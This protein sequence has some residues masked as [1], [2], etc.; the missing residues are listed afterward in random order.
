MQWTDDAFVLSARRHGEGGAVVHLLTRAHGRHAG[1]VRGAASKALRGAVQP[2]NRVVAT[3]MARLDEQLGVFA[4]ELAAAHAASVMDDAGRLAALSAACALAD[5][6]LPERQ[7][8]PAVF[9]AFAALAADLGGPD[10]PSSYVR[11]EL[12]LLAALGYGL[13]LTSCAVTGTTEGLA[14][15]SPRTGRAVS[16]GAGAAYADKLLP[17]PRF[18]VEG[19][20]GDAG[21]VAQ[22]LRLTGHFLD[23]H[24]LAG[25]PMPAARMRVVDRLGR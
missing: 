2:G 18:L 15:V 20:A 5:V 1:L 4:L 21:Q 14:W 12:V 11:W 19:G 9:D 24:V 10:W 25:K 17:L 22:G 16:A 23:R 13:D 3:W 7:A 6:T 8:H